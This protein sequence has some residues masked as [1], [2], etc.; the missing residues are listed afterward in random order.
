M[1]YQNS[2]RIIQSYIDW[3]FKVQL[4]HYRI[5]WLH[6]FGIFILHKSLLRFNGSK[7]LHALSV[8]GF[9]CFGSATTESHFNCGLFGNL[10]IVCTDSRPNKAL[11]NF[12]LCTSFFAAERENFVS[13]CSLNGHILCATCIKL[14]SVKRKHNVLYTYR[15]YTWRTN[16]FWGIFWSRTHDNLHCA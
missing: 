8:C 3:K 12:V 15:S 10:A 2:E 7:K 4:I 9:A 11:N 14:H 16:C 6:V 13:R 5:H 1:L